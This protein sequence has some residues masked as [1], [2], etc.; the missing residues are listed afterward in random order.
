MFL[1]KAIALLAL[2]VLALAF[3]VTVFAQDGVTATVQV[4]LNVRS[5]PST[6]ATR[7]AT[8]QPNT[9]V[10]VEAR[11][12]GSTWLLVRNDEQQVRGW[13]S[14]NFVFVASIGSLPVSAET[15]GNNQPTATGGTTGTTTTEAV[16]VPAGSAICTTTSAL[17]VR[18]QPSTSG[19]ILVTLPTNTTLN[20]AGRNASNSW[21]L[22]RSADGATQGWVFA[23]LV[24]VQGD[25]NAVPVTASADTYHNTGAPVTNPT[26][27][28]VDTVNNVSL[29]P[30]GR[31]IWTAFSG[32]DNMSGTC[33]SAPLV[34]CTHP[35]AVTLNSNGSITWRGQ[36]PKDYT[37]RSIGNNTFSFS[38][39]NFQGNAN[40]SL[41]LTFNSATSWNLTM[42]QVFDS[43]PTCTHVFYYSASPR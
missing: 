26:S 36:E 43:E 25:V 33:K 2:T 23:R 13:V 35:A 4:Q 41:T 8:L 19:R 27:P 31:T 11:N 21:L 14:A 24:N 9:T 28:T 12:E 22:V 37:L 32:A 40:I 3:G 34:T 39:R 7:V 18:S 38:G 10:I 30:A 29:V 5:A 20:I 1:R 17:N 16:A 15:F 6:T 42:R